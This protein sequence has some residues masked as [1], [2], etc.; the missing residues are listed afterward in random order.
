MDN[1][2]RFIEIEGQQISVT[3]EVYRAYKRPAW[4]EY[5]RK[6]REKLC[7]DDNGNRCTK[8][9]SNCKK[10]RNGTPYSLDS[11][12]DDFGFEP[13]AKIDVAELVMDKLLLEELYSVLNELDSDNRRIIELF[14]LG[15]PEREIATEVGLSQKA[16]NKRKKKLFAMLRERLKDF[17]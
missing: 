16:V 14:S 10:Q 7:R 1:Q 8:D 17:R 6:E 15:L 12:S 4:A 13:A 2:T 9:C 5:K 11:F 3:D